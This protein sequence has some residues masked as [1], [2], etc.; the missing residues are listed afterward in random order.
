MRIGLALGAVAVLAA[1]AACGSSPSPH[2]APTGSTMAADPIDLTALAAT[3]CT[4]LRP[5]QLAQF[6]IL[7][8]GSPRQYS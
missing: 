2:S 5:D 1:L 8:P 3:P 4:M 7:A 6:H